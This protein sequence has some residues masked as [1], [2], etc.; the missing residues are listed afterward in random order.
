MSE[1][2]STPGTDVATVVSPETM[3]LFA[4]MAVGI[5]EANDENAYE[6]I[7]LQLLNASDAAEL[8]APWDTD[9]AEKLAGKRIRIEVIQRRASDYADGLGIYMVC[10]GTNLESGER[11][12]WTAGSVS[13]VAQLARA[14]YLKGFPLI[15]EL[16]IADTPTKNGYRPQH[17]KVLAFGNSQ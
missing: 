7:V 11:F 17:L 13:V 15:C 6:D 2:G 14:W 5:P 10:K 4:Q 3:A 12:V 8:N 16:T 9:S 1:N